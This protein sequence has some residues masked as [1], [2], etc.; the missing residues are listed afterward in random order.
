MSC[1]NIQV[2]QQNV[3]FLPDVAL[4]NNTFMEQT[5]FSDKEINFE[6]SSKDWF[7]ALKVLSSVTA[8]LQPMRTIQLCFSNPGILNPTQTYSLLHVVSTAQ[9][10]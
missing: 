2:W 3:G 10:V 1:E 7:T 8:V 5:I 4:Q 6:Q 9:E